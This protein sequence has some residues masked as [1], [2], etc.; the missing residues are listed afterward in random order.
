MTCCDMLCQNRRHTRTLRR[1]EGAKTHYIGWVQQVAAIFSDITMAPK[2]ACTSCS[3]RVRADG[4]CPSEGCPCFRQSMRG[5]STRSKDHC[6]KCH[7]RLRVDGTCAQEGCSNFKPSYRGYSK[8]RKETVARWKVMTPKRTS[9]SS[10]S[11]ARR[12]SA[13]TCVANEGSNISAASA[14][15]HVESVSCE[16]AGVTADKRSERQSLHE[17]TRRTATGLPFGSVAAATQRRLLPSAHAHRNIA[18]YISR[19]SLLE[20]SAHVMGAAVAHCVLFTAHAILER[21]MAVPEGPTASVGAALLGVAAALSCPTFVLAVHDDGEE[22][23]SATWR[24]WFRRSAGQ[25]HLS[26]VLCLEP[27]WLMLMPFAHDLS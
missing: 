5:Q 23:S 8:W 19:P 21:C 20:E 17:L 12:L 26:S 4:S 22:V 16:A 10:R 9:T 15:T 27:Q 25:E 14:G 6:S 13:K 7:K 1:Q 11:V 24:A 2:F 18:A 3:K